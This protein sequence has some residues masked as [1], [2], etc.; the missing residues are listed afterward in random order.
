MEKVDILKN[1]FT[2]GKSFL[3]SD[4]RVLTL[5]SNGN[6]LKTEPKTISSKIEFDTLLGEVVQF[7]NDPGNK[8]SGL[9]KRLVI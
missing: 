5:D 4:I 3:E 8:G 2:Q 1:K 6:T 7:N 9:T